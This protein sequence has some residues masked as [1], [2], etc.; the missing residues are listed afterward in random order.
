MANSAGNVFQQRK[1]FPKTK[2]ASRAKKATGTKTWQSYTNKHQWVVGIVG[3]CLGWWVVGNGSWVAI[4]NTRKDLHVRTIII[5]SESK[6]ASKQLY[7]PEQTT[8][9][10]IIFS[11]RICVSF[12]LL[13]YRF[14]KK[15][16]R[17]LMPPAISWHVFNFL[18][19]F[20]F[21]A[22]FLIVF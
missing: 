22:K 14:W 4:I 9:K 8:P 17:I 21:F 18:A 3:G 5:S 7:T 12:V 1:S 6:P 16:V 11:K 13:C 19:G 15:H 2:F 20:C 10:K